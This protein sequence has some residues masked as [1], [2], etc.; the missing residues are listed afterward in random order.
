MRYS[1]DGIPLRFN[2]TKYSY[3][4]R[5]QNCRCGSRQSS[6]R[7]TIERNGTIFRYRTCRDCAGHWTSLETVVQCSATAA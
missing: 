6:I 7:A 3:L 1:A 5:P 4:E 2:P